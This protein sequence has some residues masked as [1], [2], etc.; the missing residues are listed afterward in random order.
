MKNVESRIQTVMNEIE[1]YGSE[2]KNTIRELFSK[3]VAYD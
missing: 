3:G 2:F 1:D